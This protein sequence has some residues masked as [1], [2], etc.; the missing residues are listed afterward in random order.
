MGALCTVLYTYVLDR[1]LCMQLV[2]CCVAPP[3]LPSIQCHPPPPPRIM[4]WCLDQILAKPLCTPLFLFEV[5]AYLGTGTLAS[6]ERMF[7]LEV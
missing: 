1:N 3:P 4:L 5:S 2:L 7:L 6:T